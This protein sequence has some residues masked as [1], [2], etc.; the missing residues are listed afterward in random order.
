MGL[1]EQALGRWVEADQHL[2]EALRSGSDAWIRRNRAALESALETISQHLGRLDVTCNV[3]GAVLLV[4][5]VR[6]GQTPLA[7]PVTIPVGRVSVEVRMT[8]YL[9]ATR[10]VVIE[11]GVLAREQLA[12][13]PAPKDV[14]EARPLPRAALR[15]AGW[16]TLGGSALFLAGGFAALGAREHYA[17]QWN[18][19]SRC[20]INGLTRSQNCGSDYEAAQT[21]QS[22]EIAGFVVGG[23]LAAT[24]TGLLIVSRPDKARSHARL[25]ISCAPGPLLGLACAG[26]F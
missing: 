6:V 7:D 19:D 15:L 23:V 13:A 21:A 24:A 22:L 17:Q 1:A 4:N 26:S 12:L 8:G 25:S 3:G 18:D 14:S 5:G 16:V 10:T 9:P 20:V 11:A 2:R